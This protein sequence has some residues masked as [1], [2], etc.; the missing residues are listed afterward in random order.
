MGP[1]SPVNTKFFFMRSQKFTMGSVVVLCVMKV[2]TFFLTPGNTSQ[3]FPAFPYTPG[4]TGQYLP[5]LK[6]RSSTYESCRGPGIKHIN[7]YA[8]IM[9][10]R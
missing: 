2:R 3:Y 10:P 8:F 5:A 7:T 9:K 4:N 6:K 1:V